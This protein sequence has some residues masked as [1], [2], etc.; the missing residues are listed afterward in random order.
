V[1]TISNE[2]REQQQKMHAMRRGYGGVNTDVI[3]P[4]V[5]RIAQDINAE[6]VLDY[7]AGKGHLGEY[8]FLHGFKGEYIPYDPAMPYWSDSPG[9]SDFVVCLDVLEHIEPEYLEN[10]LIDLQRVI[11]KYGLFSIHLRPAKKTLPDGRN[12]H[13]IIQPTEWW[14]ERINRHFVIVS[15]GDTFAKVDGEILTAIFHVVPLP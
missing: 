15:E 13:L 1:N 10:V 5:L 7:G 9:P 11:R 8:L 6:S 14:R 3:G 4:L 2:Y 12:A